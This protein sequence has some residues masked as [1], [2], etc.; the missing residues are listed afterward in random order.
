MSILS[1]VGQLKIKGTSRG[2]VEYNIDTATGSGYLKTN[3]KI[4]LEAWSTQDVSLT[5]ERGRKARGVIIVSYKGRGRAEM[6]FKSI[7]VK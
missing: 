7:Q 2:N 6:I 5:L 4:L 3:H 1:G